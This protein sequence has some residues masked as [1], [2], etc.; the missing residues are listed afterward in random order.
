MDLG[1][2]IVKKIPQKGQK[3]P[4]SDYHVVTIVKTSVSINF[5]TFRPTDRKPLKRHKL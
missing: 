5:Q 4:I 3:T 1:A 2:F